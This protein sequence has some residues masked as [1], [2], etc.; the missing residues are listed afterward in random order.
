MTK[1]INAGRNELQETLPLFKDSMHSLGAQILDAREDERRSIARSLH[2]ELGQL[3]TALKLDLTALAAT[4]SPADQ[5]ARLKAMIDLVDATFDAVR[6]IS[7]DLRPLVLDDVG[8]IEAIETLAR[9][10]SQ[11]MGIEVTVRREEQDPPVNA[12]VATALYRTAQEA[13]TNVARHA[14][15][16]D[17]CVDLQSQ[18]EEVILSITDNGVG[19]PQDALSRVGSWGLK[20]LRERAF[21]LGGGL[22]AQNA[23]GSGACISLRVPMQPQGA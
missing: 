18:G 16:T 17:V 13:L 12:R 8:L 21:L 1:S 9:R 3:L 15:A 22:T 14:Q 11:H 7:D 23:P 4:C 5:L 2:D 19:L 6:R 10:T 20:G